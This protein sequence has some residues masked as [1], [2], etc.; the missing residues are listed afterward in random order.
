M[1]NNTLI[2]IIILQ[3]NRP[4]LTIQLLESV[5]SKEGENVFERYR[6]ILIDNASENSQEEKIKAKFPAVEFWKFEE[7][8]GF[9]K[10]HNRVLTSLENAEWVLLINNDCILLNDAITKTVTA[11]QN[12][13]AD[14]AT[15]A[16]YNEDLSSQINYSTTPT[17]LKRL[18]L[19]ATGM[20]R[21]WSRYVRHKRKAKVGYINGAFLLLKF[22][23]FKEV[24]FFTE[25]FFM[26]TEDLD[27]ALRLDKSN[28]KGYRF[29]EGQ[30]IHLGGSTA[31]SAWKESERSK[32]LGRQLIHCY[33]KHFPRWQVALWQKLYTVLHK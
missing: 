9:A 28:Y 4:D 7:N 33:N 30:I 12:F 29:S 21:L 18:F 20:T 1:S 22:S 19:N 5:I 23:A 2:T 24:G 10:A 3:Y 16:L 27:L 8:L 6:F 32:L 11:A 14:F 31:V 25:D 17:P 15:C 26:F 13:D